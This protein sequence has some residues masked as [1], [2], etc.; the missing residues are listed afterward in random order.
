MALRTGHGNGAG[1]PRVEVLPADELPAGVPA[2]ARPEP[3]RDTAGRLL[4]SPGTTAL[5]RQGARAAH[6]CRQ[7]DRLLGLWT[8]DESH[9]YAPYARM[10][11]EWRDDHM[12]QLAAS[13][14]GG[15]V[16]PGP[17]SIVSTAAMQLAASRYLYDVGARGGDAKALLESSRLAD[18]SR[19]SLLA[20]HELCAR[21]VVARG[22]HAP[23]VPE[24]MRRL[25]VR[26]APDR[27]SPP[28]T[29]KG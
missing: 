4:P 16:G 15:S 26:P 19:Q 25:G 12:A 1:V 2:S 28:P 21:E 29:K 24:W 3:A 5:A 7:L 22:Q 27:V 9:P 6:E 10:A 23:A 14:G 17:A 8:P 13:V 11:R 18:S 20:A